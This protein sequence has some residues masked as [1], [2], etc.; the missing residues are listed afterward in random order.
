M[1]THISKATSTLA[2]C[3]TL[4]SPDPAASQSGVGV[5]I[6]R[7]SRPTPATWSKIIEASFYVPSEFRFLV[8]KSE[9][10]S[11]QSRVLHRRSELNLARVKRIEA[12]YSPERLRRLEKL[13]AFASEVVRKLGEASSP[14]LAQIARLRAVSPR[15]N[16]SLVRGSQLNQLEQSRLKRSLSK[17]LLLGYLRRNSQFADPSLIERRSQA[18]SAEARVIRRLSTD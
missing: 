2:V 8:T 5:T 17:D 7:Q 1:F 13:S 3:I 15:F 16:A 11:A 9:F 14:S 18:S 12:T 10:G 6:D 4:I